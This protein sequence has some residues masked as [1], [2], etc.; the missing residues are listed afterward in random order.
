[1][2]EETKPPTDRFKSIKETKNDVYGMDKPKLYLN[3]IPEYPKQG[4]TM[5]SKSQPRKGNHHKGTSSTMASFKINSVKNPSVW[6][7]K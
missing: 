1:M 2:V 7:H 3:I 4:R 6:R 5:Q